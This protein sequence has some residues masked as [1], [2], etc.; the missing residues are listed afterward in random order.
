MENEEE[1]EDMSKRR[2]VQVFIVDTDEDLP[3]TKA[4]L[5]QDEIPRLTDATDTELFFEVNI[6]EKLEAHNDYRA[7]CLDKQA[8][9]NA[10]KD[11]F[12]EPIRIRDLKMCV[13][14]VAEF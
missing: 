14:T 6:Q 10:G 5:H 3:L 8:S 11:I 4:I 7:R 2:V 1:E 13:A 9:I 12:L